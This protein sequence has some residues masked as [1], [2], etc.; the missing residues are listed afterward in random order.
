[1]KLAPQRLILAQE[2]AIAHQAF[3]LGEQLVEDHRLHQ[4]VVGALAEGGHRVLDRRVGRDD[5]DEQLGAEAEQL[6]QEFQAVEAGELDVAEGQVG[7]E[8]LD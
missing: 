6:F 1:M 4:V 8:P 3:E 2:P 5:Q 7:L